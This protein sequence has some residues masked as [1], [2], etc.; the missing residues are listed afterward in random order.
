MARST[1]GI[2]RAMRLCISNQRRSQYGGSTNSLRRGRCGLGTSGAQPR[3]TS[4]M[5]GICVLSGQNS[6]LPQLGAAIGRNIAA[7]RATGAMM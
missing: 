2:P 7:G 1:L 4:I 5:R 3:S 6:S